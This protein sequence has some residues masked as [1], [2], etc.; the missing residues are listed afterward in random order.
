MFEQNFMFADPVDDLVK[1]IHKIMDTPL[2][3][4]RYQFGVADETAKSKLVD[5]TGNSTVE[6]N[7]TV[8][9]FILPQ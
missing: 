9:N 3:N 5:P 4:L 8:V 2:P 7:N 1:L 6:M